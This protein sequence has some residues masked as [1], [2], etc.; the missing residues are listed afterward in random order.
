[1]TIKDIYFA[2]ADIGHH[3]GFIVYNI[4]KNEFHSFDD[5]YKIPECVRN[6]KVITFYRQGRNRHFNAKF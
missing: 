1:M 6:A 4:D 5:W 2:C 3:D